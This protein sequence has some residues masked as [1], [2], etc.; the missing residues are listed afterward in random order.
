[1]PG[2]SSGPLKRQPAASRAPTRVR[3]IH[4]R[5]R[6]LGNR[7]GWVSEGL[8]RVEDHTKPPFRGPE[9]II[10]KDRREGPAPSYFCARRL[11][12]L[13]SRILGTLTSSENP[14]CRAQIRPA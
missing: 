13:L 2:T 8:L 10:G 12:I 7:R 14:V 9:W 5:G 3:S 11:L 4:V 1:M 6:G